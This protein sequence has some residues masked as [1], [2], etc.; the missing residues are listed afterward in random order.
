M[1]HAFKLARL[2]NGD[3][4]CPPRNHNRYNSNHRAGVAGKLLTGKNQVEISQ[5]KLVTNYPV[6]VIGAGSEVAR[7]SRVLWPVWTGHHW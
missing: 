4:G 6:L 2:K 5:V 3:D 7:L 1:V